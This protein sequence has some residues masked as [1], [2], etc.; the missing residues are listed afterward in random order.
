MFGLSSGGY[1]IGGTV[2]GARSVE[3]KCEVGRFTCGYCLRNAPPWL[4]SF[5]TGQRTRNDIHGG[6]RTYL[7][8]LPFVPPKKEET[9]V[10]DY[11]VSTHSK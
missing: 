8:E 7:P 11:P 3:C 1:G 2:A 4:W 10:Q 6:F 5:P 9:D